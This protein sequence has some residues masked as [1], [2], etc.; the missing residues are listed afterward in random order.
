[1]SLGIDRLELLELVLSEKAASEVDVDVWLCCETG[2]EAGVSPLQPA[3]DRTS[4]DTRIA[5]KIL[6]FI[7]VSPCKYFLA[8]R[9]IIRKK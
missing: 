9:L 7:F 1:M 8:F 3:I 6:F 5:L 2:S 4:D